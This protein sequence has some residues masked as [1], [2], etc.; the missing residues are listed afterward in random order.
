MKAQNTTI[1][2]RKETKKRLDHFKE[3]K[4][5]SYEEVIKKM[6]YIMSTARKN[7]DAARRILNNIDKNIKRKKLINKEF[8]ATSKSE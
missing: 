1:K 7:P 2:V 8:K 3:H 4:S 6:L 5:E